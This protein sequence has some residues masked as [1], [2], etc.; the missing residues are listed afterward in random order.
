MKFIL[1]FLMLIPAWSLI[2][3]VERIDISDTSVKNNYFGMA[4]NSEGDYF[5]A[6][7]D[8]DGGG[9]YSNNINSSNSNFNI[10]FDSKDIFVFSVNILNFTSETNSDDI[11]LAGGYFKNC[12]CGVLL[13]QNKRTGEWDK[14]FFDDIDNPFTAN[15]FSIATNSPNSDGTEFS[16]VFL[17]CANSIIYYSDDTARTFKKSNIKADNDVIRKI[18]FVNKSTG[19]ALAG[20]DMNL[21]S[22]IFKTVDGG[23]NW[24]LF[25]DFTTEYIAINDSWI[26]QDTILIAGSK[27]TDGMIMLSTDA[28]ETFDFIK[29][30][31]KPVFPAS[32]ISIVQQGKRIYAVDENGVIYASDETL[33]NWTVYSN[34][35]PLGKFTNAKSISGKIIFSGYSGKVFRTK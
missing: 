32:I 4:V 18:T 2:G 3:Q 29:Y 10:L 23:Q 35:S 9:I 31:N 19:F 13:R 15:I 1:M 21:M 12:Q 7:V 20:K 30:N 26:N 5:L 14:V 22:K 28:G 6:G 16:R 33:R 34:S 17:A 8:Y 27:L 11:L 24:A 25:K